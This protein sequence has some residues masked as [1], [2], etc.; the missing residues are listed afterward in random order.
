MY[1]GCCAAEKAIQVNI[2]YRVGPLGFLAA[3]EAGIRGNFGTQDQLLAL[4]WIKAN[5]ELFGGDAVCLFIILLT[6]LA[7]NC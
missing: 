4:K 6:F 2:N 3:D 5:I 7:F 1:T